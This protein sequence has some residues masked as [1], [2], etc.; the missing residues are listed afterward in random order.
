MRQALNTTNLY[1]QLNLNASVAAHLIKYN[2]R[3]HEH[4]KSKS[5][6]NYKNVTEIINF[7][8]AE[9]IYIT[10]DIYLLFSFKH[11]CRQIIFQKREI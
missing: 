1:L 6:E 2:I 11:F 3:A 10:I 9:Y 8:I 4:R 5:Q 7:I